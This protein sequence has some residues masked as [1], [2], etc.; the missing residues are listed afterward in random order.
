[1][2]RSMLRRRFLTLASGCGA[3]LFLKSK[4]RLLGDSILVS[5]NPLIAEF[6]LQSPA[7]R[8]TPT[9]DFYVRNHFP[10]PQGQPTGALSI[11]GEV[12]QPVRLSSGDLSRLNNKELCVA[13]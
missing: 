6:N 13:T 12:E 5:S 1:M 8:Y 2:L 7:G 9:E 3:A 4:S 10:I 11:Q